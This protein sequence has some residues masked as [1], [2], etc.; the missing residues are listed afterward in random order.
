LLFNAHIVVING[1]IGRMLIVCSVVGEPRG[2]VGQLGRRKVRDELW[3]VEQ[4]ILLEPGPGE[5]VIETAHDFVVID[6][7]SAAYHGLSALDRRPRKPPPRT[8]VLQ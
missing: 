6:S 4:R 3:V 7:I 8:K 1:R 5:L 2:Y